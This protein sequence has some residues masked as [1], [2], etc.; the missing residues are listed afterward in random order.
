MSKAGKKEEEFKELIGAIDKGILKGKLEFGS[1]KDVFVSVD[2]SIEFDDVTYLI[3]IDASNMAKL[4]AGQYTL[5]NVLKNDQSERSM[6][7]ID[8]SKSKQLVFLVIH[9]FG[10]GPTKYNSERSIK[11]FRKINETLLDGA[12]IKFASI[13]IEDLIIELTGVKTKID[14]K[15]ILNKLVE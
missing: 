11:N 9:Y 2:N 3:E 10:K 5:L 12:G 13:H 4:V 15:T 7:I 14:L 8:C 1:P 6:G